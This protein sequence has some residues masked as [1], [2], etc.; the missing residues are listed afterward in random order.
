MNWDNSILFEDFKSVEIPTYKWLYGLVIWWV[1]LGGN[2]GITENLI[3]LDLIEI[4]QFCLKIYDVL[5]TSQPMGIYISGL[6]DG[7]VDEWGYVKSL[8]IE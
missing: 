3:K 7:W 2:G 5:Q 8:K 6:V 1:D 4:I